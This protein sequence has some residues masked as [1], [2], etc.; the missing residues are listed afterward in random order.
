MK[1]TALLNRHVSALVAR[2]GHL[3]EIVIADAGLPVPDTVPVID[4]AVIPGLPGFFDILTALRSELVIEAAVYAS[5]A[6]PD[7]AKR[8][9]AELDIWSKECDQAITVGTA[10]HNALKDRSH[11]A[12]AVIRTGEVTPYANLVLVSGVAF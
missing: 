4:L 12:K 6:S 1:R 9:E 10:S 8:I 11:K 7:L 5:E 3:D 2:L